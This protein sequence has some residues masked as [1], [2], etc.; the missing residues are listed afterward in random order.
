MKYFIQKALAD[1]AYRVNDGCPDPHNRT[2]IQVLES[3]LRQYG[4]TENFISEYVSRVYDPLLRE[5]DED[6]KYFHKGQGVYV[7]L[8]DKDKEDATKYQKTDDG[9]YKEM[10]GEED[11]KDNREYVKKFLNTPEKGSD[12]DVAN[13][14]T[15][16][17]PS[18]PEQSISG[19]LT[20]GDN[21]DQED[22]LK[23]GADGY[24]KA[25]GKKKAPGNAGSAYNEIVSGQGIKILHE[26]SDMSEEELART[27][28]EKFGKTALGKEQSKSSG[29][30]IPDD[31]KQARKDAKASGDREALKGAE[32][33][34]ATY[35]KCVIAARSAQKKSSISNRRVEV[36][37]KQGV[38]GEPN[39]PVTF[40]G[41]EKSLTA[42]VD[43]VNA[44]SKVILPD[45]SVVNKDVV[46]EF[47]LEG[48]KGDNPSDTATFVTD[49]KGNLLIQ[50]HS[51]KT[52]TADIQDNTTLKKETANVRTRIE[53]DTSLPD[54]ERNLALLIV[55]EIDDRVT[56]IEDNYTKQGIPIANRL[57]EL[58]DTFEQQ[59]EIIEKG[60]DTKRSTIAKN[61]NDALFGARGV[62]KEYID[63][64][65][66]GMDLSPNSPMRDKYS[67]ILAA[68]SSE[69]AKPK[70]IKVTNKVG[71]ALAKQNPE[72]QG[73]NVQENL[74]QQRKQAV[75]ALQERRDR[76]NE[77]S[78]G[79][80]E[81]QE[82]EETIRGFHLSILDDIPYDNTSD[83]QTQKKAI[84]NSSF[85]VN[86][87]GVIV[88]KQV[89]RKTLGVSSVREFRDKFK[90]REVEEYTYDSD[91]PPNV[92]GKKVYTYVVSEGG[93][94]LELGFKTYRSKQGATGKSGVTLQYSKQFQEKL[95][96]VQ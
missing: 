88:N 38:F 1:W 34:I 66:D 56:K 20:Q 58:E 79:L 60:L 27:L 12:N 10:E 81:K 46:S 87:G 90:V 13:K 26:S 44:A 84:L 78:P 76:L 72:L 55:D 53:N 40:Y 37:Q 17:T 14:T 77:V 91:I 70:D 45:G 59:V 69:S 16:S 3:V 11:S 63:L 73:L 86:M 83:S 4:C 29:I 23:Y 93:E 7:K 39:A 85:D 71:G 68:A 57:K 6:E 21:Q 80:G 82:A 36:L 42:Q 48:G 25:T 89:L 19:D 62:K 9:K 5:S 2:H 18:T 65:P 54:K 8:G 33:A 95:K 96:A 43:M 64:I 47:I 35:S 67:I 30:P 49:N 31:L 24:E 52:S 28:F 15:S 32:Q 51:D 41:T 22:M 75:S 94:E 50:F 74:S 92:T 61:I